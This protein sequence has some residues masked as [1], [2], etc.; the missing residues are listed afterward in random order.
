[1]STTSTLLPER[2]DDT[3][4]GLP[5]PPPPARP[6]ML[7]IATGLAVGGVSMAFAAL[8]GVYLAERSTTL[9]AGQSWLPKGVKL[10]ITPGN[11]AL[12]CL[13]LS[14]FMIQ[15]AVDAI[16]RN[17]RPR[18]YIAMGLTALL[19][20][21]YINEI[22]FGYSQ[23]NVPLREPFGLLFYALTGG[24]LAMAAGGLVFLGL[25]AFRTIGGQYSG[26]DR[27]GITAVALYW[28]VM[29]AVYTVI[30]FTIFIK[31]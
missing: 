11:M 7:L 4:I 30:W 25:V 14:A 3:T 6:R 13:A 2:L 22:A 18:A 31:K 20:A 9:A 26:R 23:F 16:G 17:D 29:I 24:H 5:P 12:A 21:A 27:E 15:W 10:P 1:L 28:Y 8:L 19:G